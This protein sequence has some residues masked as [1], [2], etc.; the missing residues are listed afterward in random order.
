MVVQDSD[1]TISILGITGSIGQNAKKVLLECDKRYKIHTLSANNNVKLL[2]SSAIELKAEC[3]VIEN[4]NLY[5]E[6]KELLKNTKIEVKA[7]RSALLESLSRKTDIVLSAISGAIALEPTITAM[8]YG[9]NIALANKECL[10]CA[11]DIFNEIAKK[12]SVKIIPVD[13]EHSAIFQ[14]LEEE[15]K[16]NIAKIVITASGGPFRNFSLKQLENV[17]I[18]QA[19]KHPNWSMGAKI[20]IDSATM[21]NKA[22]EIIEA[23][24]LF[25]LD[26]EQIDVLI[27]PQSLVHGV[28][29]YKDGSV[30]AH[31]GNPDMC[32]PI[33]YALA[34]PR[35]TKINYRPLN[36][37]QINNL[38]FEVVDNKKFPAIKLAYGAISEGGI[39]PLIFNVANEIAVNAFLTKKISF[40]KITQ[41]VELMLNKFNYKGLPGNI[42]DVIA[43]VN[44]VSKKTQETIDEHK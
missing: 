23:H 29:E 31:L 38:T 33:A 42:N 13:S 12:N 44:E 32:T 26:K 21:M 40:L 34:W 11:G 4:E 9:A 28:V 7:G 2:A 22:L 17:T 39:K 35:R 18:E 16:D 41:I 43:L 36:L 10:V 3:A 1:N 8:N 5:A 25:A 24:Y 20:T 19:L 30:L 14:L 37:T 6:L 15:N 27:H